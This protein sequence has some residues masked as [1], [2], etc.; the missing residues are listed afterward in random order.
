MQMLGIMPIPTSTHSCI[1]IDTCILISPL[2]LMFLVKVQNLPVS[3]LQSA[4]PSTSKVAVGS[5]TVA[6]LLPTSLHLYLLGPFQL[7]PT[8]RWAGAKH[9][10]R[11][12]LYHLLWFMSLVGFVQIN[13]SHCCK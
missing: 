7:H 5:C 13:K 1:I 4:E 10:A 8:A 2:I 6:L 12:S 11:K 3:S 9:A